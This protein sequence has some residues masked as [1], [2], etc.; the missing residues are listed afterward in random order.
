AAER[1]NV[2]ITKFLLNTQDVD[3]YKSDCFNQS[4][5]AWASKMGRAKVVDLL[6]AADTGEVGH[7]AHGALVAT[8]CSQVKTVERLIGTA[9]MDDGFCSYG[10]YLLCSAAL[11]GEEKVVELYLA[12]GIDYNARD[13][14]GSPA[15]CLASGCHG[16]VMK[17][18]IAAGANVN[19]SDFDGRT[20]LMRAVETGYKTGVEILLDVKSIN[21]NTKGVYGDTAL[22]LAE[23][24][25]IVELLHLFTS[26]AELLITAGADVN[27]SDSGGRTPLMQAV[28]TGYKTRVEIL[29]DAKGINVNA[30]GVYGDTALSLT[31]HEELRAAE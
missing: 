25:E 6:L 14:D 1:G 15:L 7:Y 22:S 27:L 10:K 11:D 8:P 28:E 31:E 13:G 20:P 12:A 29:L 30:N 18:L 23:H 9:K 17:L 26:G 21:V 4:P 16:A 24:E 5:L 3:V 19:L 2:E